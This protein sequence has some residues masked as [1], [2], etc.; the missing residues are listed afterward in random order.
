[1]HKSL[2]LVQDTVVIST[3]SR[4]TKMSIS[5]SVVPRK[6]VAMLR[7]PYAHAQYRV[8]FAHAQLGEL[9]AP[10]PPYIYIP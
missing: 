2:P 6:N 7:A 9:P 4:Y 1:M 3:E 10:A 5:S 8:A